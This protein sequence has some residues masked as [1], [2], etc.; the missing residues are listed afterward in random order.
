MP[1]RVIV[2]VTL[3]VLFG[4]TGYLLWAL[5]NAIRVE[6]RRSNLPNTWA[7]FS[8][9][10]TFCVLFLVSWISQAIAEWGVYRGEQITHGEPASVG[11]FLVAFGQS[12]FENWQSEFL[13][14]FA[15][16]VLSAVLIHHGSAESKDSD[17]R[18]ERQ[19]TEINRKLDELSSGHGAIRH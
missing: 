12:T 4:I 2:W 9:S 6:R 15:F 1:D 10:I 8:L 18:M 5:V 14:L 19:L 3:V 16:V 11:G 17:E 13:Q 7:N